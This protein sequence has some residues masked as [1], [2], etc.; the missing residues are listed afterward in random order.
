MNTRIAVRSRTLNL[1]PALNIECA[2]ISTA[3]DVDYG[4]TVYACRTA[5]RLSVV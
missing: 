1:T 5:V 2:G 4:F 3:V